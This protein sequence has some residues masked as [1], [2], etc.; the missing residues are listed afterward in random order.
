MLG[1]YTARLGIYDHCRQARGSWPTVIHLYADSSEYSQRLWP[2]R[3]GRKWQATQCPP[4]IS[5]NSGS[6]SSQIFSLYM[7]R[8]WK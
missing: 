4:P 7:Q 5:L 6:T 2:Y 8:V 3:A 1:I